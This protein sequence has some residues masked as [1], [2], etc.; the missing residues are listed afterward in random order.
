MIAGRHSRWLTILVGPIL[1]LIAFVVT[2]YIDPLNFSSQQAYA[3]LPAFLLSIL[4]LLVNHQITTSLEVQKTSDYSDRIFEAI[5][6][7]MHVTPI[8]SPEKAQSYINTRIS[9]LK[10]VK[11]TSFNIEGIKERADDKFYD[12]ETYSETSRQA[13][14][15]IS[16]GLIWMEVGDKFAVGRFRSLWNATAALVG[17]GNVRYRYRLLAHQEP[18]INFIILEYK[19][20]SSEVLF[21]WDLRNIGQDPVVLLSREHQIVSMFSVQFDYL[22]KSGSKDHDNSASR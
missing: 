20:G 8:G 10:E 12:T 16:Q 3:A 5:K 7:Y 13:A 19:D 11:N 6:N 1:S 2:Y 21:N 22:W 4:I 15:H 17:D 14:L 9:S 18:Q